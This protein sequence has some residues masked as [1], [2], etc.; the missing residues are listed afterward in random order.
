M[1]ITIE[2]PAG[3]RCVLLCALAQRLAHCEHMVD[4]IA[5][6]GSPDVSGYA[7]EAS[8]CRLLMSAVEGSHA[9]NC[10]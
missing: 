9:T 1:T 3:G 8:D 5:K 4:L 10:V 2:I 6:T 7:A